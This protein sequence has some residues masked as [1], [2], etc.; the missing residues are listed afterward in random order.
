[1]ENDVHFLIELFM[2]SRS[3]FSAFEKV[4]PVIQVWL[5]IVFI[6]L[7]FQI[8]MLVCLQI[9]FLFDIFFGV[10]KYCKAFV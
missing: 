1:M 10:N 7:P 9:K 4:R 6:S 3:S 2:Q 5:Y 8:T